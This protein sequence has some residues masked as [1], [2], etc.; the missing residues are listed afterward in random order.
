[1]RTVMFFDEEYDDYE[2][3]FDAIIDIK[4]GGVPFALLNQGYSHRLKISF[5]NF[6]DSDYIPEEWKANIIQSPQS[7]EDKEKMKSALASV[8]LETKE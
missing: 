7:R 1:M 8:E 3:K 6:W 4:N 5:F 2:K